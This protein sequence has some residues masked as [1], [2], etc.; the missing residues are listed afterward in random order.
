MTGD[1]RLLQLPIPAFK[2]DRLEQAEGFGGG[3]VGSGVRGQGSGE[4]GAE[5]QAV[6]NKLQHRHTTPRCP[7]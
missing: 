3:G 7:A 1:L 5:T 6:H 2:H 4:D